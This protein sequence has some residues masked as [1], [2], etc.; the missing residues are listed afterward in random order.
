LLET[1]LGLSIVVGSRK[2]RSHETRFVEN[3]TGTLARPVR[4]GHDRILA[5]SC[6]AR[7]RGGGLSAT[8]DRAEREH[9]HVEDL[10]QLERQLMT[11]NGDTSS[12]RG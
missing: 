3:A 11:I 1:A 10:Y 8:L 2:E 5:V 12:S 9:Y 7:S 4:S 6:G